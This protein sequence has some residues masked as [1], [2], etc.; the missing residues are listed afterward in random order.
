MIWGPTED[1]VVFKPEMHRE[2]VALKENPGMFLERLRLLEGWAQFYVSALLGGVRLVGKLL[3]ESNTFEQNA[4]Q[5]KAVMTVVTLCD[6]NVT[7]R[8]DVTVKL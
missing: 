7:N 6:G 2:Y 4:R 3:V 5:S 1:F 8:H